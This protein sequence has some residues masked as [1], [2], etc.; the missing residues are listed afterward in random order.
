MANFNYNKTMLA[1]RLTAD[2]E[3]TKTPSNKAVCKLSVAVSRKAQRDKSDFFNVVAWEKTAE[4]ISK[5][6][7]KGSS[8][9]VEGELQNRNYEDSKGITRYVTELI[10]S[11]VRFVDS[12]SDIEAEQPKPKMQDLQPIEDE[13][14]PF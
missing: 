2:P 13:Q 7:K 10:V 6:F 8:I 5:Y 3:L 9:F 11:D 12:K 1:G 4:F 14:L